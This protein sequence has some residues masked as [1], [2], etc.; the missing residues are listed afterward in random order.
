MAIRER[1]KLRQL[2]S[3]YYHGLVSDKSYREQRAQ[4]LDNLGKET[5][6]VSE[7]TAKRP[8]GST[9]G[10]GKKT[11]FPIVPAAIGVVVVVA[12]AAATLVF[13]DRDLE[14]GSREPD[15]AGDFKPGPSLL[16]RG[17]VLVDEF[18]SRMDW[19]DE[20]VRNFQLAWEAL[21]D[22]QRERA[23]AGRSY[24]SLTTRLHQR[25]REEMALG[26]GTG[27]ANLTVLAEFAEAIGAPFRQSLAAEPDEPPDVVPGP[28]AE[29][30]EVEPEQHVDQAPNDDDHALLNGAATVVADVADAQVDKEPIEPDVRQDD[31]QDTQATEIS[32]AEP[33]T[34]TPV[35]TS[36]EDPCPA[37]LVM[38]R[39]PYCR[40]VLADGSNGPALVVLPAGSFLMGDDKYKTEAPAHQVEIDYHIAMSRF[41]IT[42]EDF[43]R[44]CLATGRPCPEQRWGSDYPVVY[45]SW[46]DAVFYAK[47]LSEVTGFSYRLPSEAEWEFAAR[48]GTRTPY[49]FGDEITPSAAHSSRNGDW[50]S[51][52]PTGDRSVNRN[53]FRL[54]HMSGNVR[55]WAQDSW[56]PS[57]DGA[58]INGASRTGGMGDLRVVRGGSYRDPAIK[59]RSAAREPLQRNYS[60]DATGFRIVREVA[61]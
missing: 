8:P 13:L 40:D 32:A 42:A 39:R 59:L 35:A 29:R 26:A 61:Q 22:S 46:D 23:I 3:D 24:R 51:P 44:F 36:V 12:V 16:D 15:V 55:E 56:N 7:D 50:D 58:V 37:S 52:L 1:D 10:R 20:S 43:G 28:A 5:D 4:L 60:D 21:D 9:A 49:F 18:L 57:Y 17:D 31:A 6:D 38:T 54:Y 45:V 11:S 33:A 25:I 19:S 53:P 47:W 34:E 14:S 41:E 2:V 27:N 48:A 30:P